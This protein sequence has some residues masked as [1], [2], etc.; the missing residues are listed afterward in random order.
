MLVSSCQEA[1]WQGSAS[2]GS[3]VKAS[4]LFFFFFLA[5]DYGLRMFLHFEDFPGS[6]VVKTSPSNGV[7]SIPGQG[8][9]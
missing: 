2:Y 8:A 7:G 6:L 1:L 5:V 3:W 4:L 9:K